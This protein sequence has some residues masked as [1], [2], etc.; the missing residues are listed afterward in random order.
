[1]GSLL[2]LDVLILGCFGI[3]WRAI[4]ARLDLFEE[5]EHAQQK[6]RAARAEKKQPQTAA[7]ETSSTHYTESWNRVSTKQLRTIGMTPKA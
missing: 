5:L 4:L 2:C 1:M 7:A 6:D 3:L